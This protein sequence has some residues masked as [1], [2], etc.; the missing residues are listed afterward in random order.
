MSME[1][2]EKDSDCAF[3]LLYHADEAQNGLNS[4]ITIT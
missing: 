4:R 3:L 1:I 2:L